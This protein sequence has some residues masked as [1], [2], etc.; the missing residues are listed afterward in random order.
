MSED[1][2]VRTRT[3]GYNMKLMEFKRPTWNCF[4]I[5]PEQRYSQQT[6]FSSPKEMQKTNFSLFILL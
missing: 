1:R 5:Y 3:M 4:E 2:R 6:I